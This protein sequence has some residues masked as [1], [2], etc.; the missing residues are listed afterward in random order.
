MR[1]LHDWAH[2]PDEL[3]YQHRQRAWMVDRV[4]AAMGGMRVGTLVEVGCGDGWV[5]H[6]LT[7]HADRVVGFDMNPHRIEPP[8]RP[9]L[10]LVAGEAERP[11]LREG[12]GDLLISIAVLEHLVDRAGALRGQA[13]LVKP[14]GLIVQIVPTAPMKVMQ[15]LGFYPHWARKQV[16][17]VTRSLAG[18]RT[19]REQK[20]AKFYEG[21]ETN[22]PHRRSRRRWWQKLYP[23]VHG[24]Y[25]T[26]WQ[27]YLHNRDAAWRAVFAEAGFEVTH[28]VRLG[29]YSPYFFGFAWLARVASRVGLASVRGYVLT[30][31]GS[32][33]IDV[34]G[35]AGDRG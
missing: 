14:G 21:R 17:G 20:P 28:N 29:L 18:R 22:N 9:G 8:R 19:P 32:G 30:R 31:S 23:R 34:D 11:P 25:D 2:R 4:F 6:E 27:E 24:E 3:A 10:L 16:R 35:A 5:S 26:N 13:A 12:C 7:R 1:F 15:W 33:P